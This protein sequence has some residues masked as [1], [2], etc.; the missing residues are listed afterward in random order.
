VGRSH[1]TIARAFNV[2]LPF[3]SPT[4]PTPIIQQSETHEQRLH[5]DEQFR[6]HFILWRM[7][8]NPNKTV[9]GVAARSA[10]FPFQFSYPT[11]ERL[12]QEMKISSTQ[13]LKVP[14]MTDRHKKYR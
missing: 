3:F 12:L 11:A 9:R 6:R 5:P 7:T 14:A 4:E 13:T 10:K 2:H 1:Q 8:E